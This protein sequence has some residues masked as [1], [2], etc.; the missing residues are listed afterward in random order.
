MGEFP[1]SVFVGFF[2]WSEFERLIDDT[3]MVY[4][5]RVFLLIY[6]IFFV[7]LELFWNDNKLNLEFIPKSHPI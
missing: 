7:F 1:S 5:V 6:I 3:E 4:V 2:F